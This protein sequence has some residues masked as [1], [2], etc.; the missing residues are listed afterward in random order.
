[1]GKRSKTRLANGIVSAAIVVFFLAHGTLGALSL[2]TGFSSPYSWL[3][4]FG[5][6]LIVVHVVLSIVTSR[7]QLNDQKRPPSQRKKRH[8]ALKWATG[9]GLAACITAHVLF[10]DTSIT[11]MVI[12][13]VAVMLAVHL[14][15]GS[16]SLLADLNIDRRFQLA[17]RVIVCAFAVFF[18]VTAFATVVL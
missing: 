12:V 7:E 10:K 17:F 2:V 16:K 6:G 18:V 15:V 14:C 13:A 5:A 1:M 4:W 8:L 3:V 9:A 11:W